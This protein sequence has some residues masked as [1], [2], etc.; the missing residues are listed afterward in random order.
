MELL[1]TGLALALPILLGGVWLGRWFPTHQIAL[2]WGN[3]A[4]V[5][6]LLVPLMMRLQVSLGLPLSF[7]ITAPICSLLIVLGG[8]L[9]WRADRRNPPSPAND[10]LQSAGSRLLFGL[11]LAMIALRLGTLSL[12]VIWR[13]LF[14][15]DATM[16]WA[17]KSRVWFE[18]RDIVPFVTNQQWLE[19]GDSNV[20][21]DRHPEYPPTIP[22]LQVW[23]N[24]ALGR[25]SESLMNLPWLVCLAGLGAAFYGQLRAAAV[26]PVVAMAFCYFLLSMPLLNIHV[27]L[28][29]YAD[30]FVAASY[31]GALMALHNWSQRRE[32][33]QLALMLLFAIL[34]ATIKAEGLVWAATLIPAVA[35]F[36]TPVKH[37]L[38]LAVALVLGATL[39]LLVS[40]RWDIGIGGYSWGNTQITVEAESLVGIA[41]STWLYDNWHLLA[42]LLLLLLPVC[43]LKPAMLRNF[44]ALGSALAVAVGLFLFLFLFTGF[45][46]GNQLY[47][48]VSRL[49]LHLVP[50]LLFLAALLYHQLLEEQHPPRD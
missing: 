50:G 4:L 35:V 6:L 15:W 13:P 42:Y 19:T 2:V 43:L 14:P 18:A 41:R 8:L 5:G 38:K 12:E 34:C 11:L 23:M 26:Q 31:C 46:A 17:T 10:A 48:A 33:G 25:W 36:L 1:T 3:G 22:L 30:L 40:D 7:A 28:A 24:L 9:W 37:L 21:T 44:V 27:A 47:A 49:S 45:G 32:H 39:G 29:G 20:F 16:H